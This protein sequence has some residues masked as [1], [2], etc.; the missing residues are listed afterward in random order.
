MGRKTDVLP[1]RVI[2]HVVAIVLE[3][4]LLQMAEFTIRVHEYDTRRVYLRL[5]R[6]LSERARLR[7]AAHELVASIIPMN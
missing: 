1:L 7:M 4:S 3:T 6:L 5:L 2:K